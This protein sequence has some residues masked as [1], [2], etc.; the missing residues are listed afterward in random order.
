MKTEVL[1]TSD[2]KAHVRNIQQ[3]LTEVIDHVREDIDKVNEPKAQVLFETTAEVL[4]GVR[5]AYEHYERGSEK[6][7]R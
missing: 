2:P 3:M 4:I 5:T 7:M 1:E 6:A